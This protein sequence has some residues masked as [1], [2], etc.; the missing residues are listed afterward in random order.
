M[1][2]NVEELLNSITPDIYQQ[3]KLAVEIGKWGNGTPISKEQRALCM[4]AMIAYEE[5]H[6]SPE[7]RTAYIPPREHTHCGSTQGSVADD[8]EQP[9]NF[10][11]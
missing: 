4:Q 7:A 8:S 2:N 1:F 3:L 11:E 10:K 9:L 5:K 6:V